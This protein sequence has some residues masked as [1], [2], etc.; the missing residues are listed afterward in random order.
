MNIVF[1]V[2]LGTAVYVGGVMYGMRYIL[3]PMMKASREQYELV[4]DTDGS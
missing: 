3:G 1:G 2:A 4:E